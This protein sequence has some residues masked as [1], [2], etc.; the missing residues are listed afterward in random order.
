MDYANS[1]KEIVVALSMTILGMKFAD[2]KITRLFTNKKIYYLSIVRLI[3]SPILIVGALLLLRLATPISDEVVIA[4]YIAFAMPTAAMAP[5]IADKFKIDSENSVLYT[6]GTT[7]FS[8]ITI[9]LLY[10]LLNLVI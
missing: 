4:T 5:T 7:L 9:P 6:L 8:V 10:L 3:V 1:F 2:I